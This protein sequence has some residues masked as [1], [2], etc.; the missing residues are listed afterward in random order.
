MPELTVYSE[1]QGPDIGI[2]HGDFWCGN[3]LLSPPGS[4]SS[5]NWSI[6]VTDFE[7]THVSLASADIGQMLAE[8]YLL[9]HFW[10][11]SEALEMMKGLLSTYKLTELTEE[12]RFR[13]GLQFGVHLVVWPPFTQTWIDCGE[14]RLKDCVQYGVDCISAAHRK[15]EHFWKSHVL[16]ALFR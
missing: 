7:L 6:Y 2:I 8:L 11:R 13:V 15:D 9:Y 16:G 14:E 3:L 4:K 12:L 1:P 10:S 5:T